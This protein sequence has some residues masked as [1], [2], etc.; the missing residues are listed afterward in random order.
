VEALHTLLSDINH[1]PMDTH[2]ESAEERLSAK[3][4]E[5]RDKAERK[6]EKEEQASMSFIQPKSSYS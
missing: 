1:H 3:E 6:R 2:E 4:R 5:D